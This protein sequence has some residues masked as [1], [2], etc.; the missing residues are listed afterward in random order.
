[1]KH[2]FP[3]VLLSV[4][5]LAGCQQGSPT[6]E[7]NTASS[8]SIPTA[9]SS[10][11]QNVHWKTYQDVN[12]GISIDYPSDGYSVTELPSDDSIQFGNKQINIEGI[13]IGDAMAEGNGIQL[14]RTQNTEILD[15]LK[16]QDTFSQKKV[17]NGM[18]WQEYECTGGCM[19]DSY[20]YMTEKNGWHYVFESMWGPNNSVSERMLESLKFE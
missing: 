10:S 19:G 5:I 9:A 4:I 12:L 15:A 17:I 18:A 6:A 8:S 11:G 2:I 14:Y 20:G 13:R 3:A 7:N 1:M 16:Q